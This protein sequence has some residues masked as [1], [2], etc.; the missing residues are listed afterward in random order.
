MI[1]A[2]GRTLVWNFLI[3]YSPEFCLRKP[4]EKLSNRFAGCNFRIHFSL[5]CTVVFKVISLVDETVVESVMKEHGKHFEAFVLRKISG[6]YF[7][8]CTGGICSRFS[9]YT[10]LVR[11]YLFICILY[12]RYLAFACVFFFFL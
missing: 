6:I 2:D 4:N 10:F 3:D 12:A 9:L 11:Y 1:P 8:V 7:V 5:V